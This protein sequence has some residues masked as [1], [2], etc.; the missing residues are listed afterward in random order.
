MHNQEDKVCIYQD[1]FDKIALIMLE[2]DFVNRPSSAEEI[3]DIFDRI[4]E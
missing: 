3:N 1:L 4:N 2:M